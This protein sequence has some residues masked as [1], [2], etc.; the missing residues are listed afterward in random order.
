M[1][2]AVGSVLVENPARNFDTTIYGEPSQLLLT[3]VTGIDEF[4]NTEGF[5]VA[6][7]YPNPFSGSTKYN[8][9]L[10][11]E[12]DVMLTLTN[13]CKRSCLAIL[14]QRRMRR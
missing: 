12:K 3:W 5:Q 10:S 6:Q 9:K 7:N 14:F 11:A 1:Y 2:P 13:V 4:T 8:I